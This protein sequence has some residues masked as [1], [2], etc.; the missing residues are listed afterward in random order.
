M[1][2]VDEGR[3]AHDI[4]LMYSANPYKIGSTPSLEWSQGWL[5]SGTTEVIIK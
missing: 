1:D 5:L 4:G 3:K 2:Y